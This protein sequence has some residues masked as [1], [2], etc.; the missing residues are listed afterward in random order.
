MAIPIIGQTRAHEEEKSPLP[1]IDAHFPPPGTAPEGKHPLSDDQIRTLLRHPSS[2]VR[3]YAVEQAIE[4]PGDGWNEALLPMVSDPDAR[5]A[6]DAIRAMEER[7]VTAAVDAIVERFS[8]GSHEVA[9]VAA[10][11]LGDLAPEKLLDAVKQRK[12]LDDEAYAATAI[13]L[14]CIGSDEVADFLDKALN[15]AGALAPER[16]GALYGACLLAG[17]TELASRIVSLAVEDSKHDEPEGATYPTRSAF[18]AV[19][20]LPLPYSRKAAGLEVFDHARSTLESDTLPALAETDRPRFEEALRAKKVG[21]VLAALEPILDFKIPKKEEMHATASDYGNVPQRRLGLLRALIGRRADIGALDLKAGAV[22]L[23]A[24]AYAAAMIAASAGREET[25]AGLVTL[26]KTLE[27][28][29]VGAAEL[30]SMSEADLV[31]LFKDKSEHQMRRVVGILTHETLHHPSTLRRFARAIFAAG[32]GEA[33]FEA[34][35]EVEDP[36]IHD[37]VLRALAADPRLA[38]KTLVDA[39]MKTPLEPKLA[40][41]A[42]EGADHVRTERVALAIG[43]RFVELREIARPAVVRAM[44]HIGDPR[45]IELLAARAFPDEP[46]ELAWALLM[47]VHGKDGGEKLER[48]LRHADEMVT[49]EEIAALRLPMRCK[50]CKEVLTYA[51]ERALLD[52][53]SKDPFGDPAFVGETTCKACGAEGELEPTQ[54]A[55]RILTTHMLEF[56]SAARSGRP[57][58]RPRVMP[59]ETQLRGKRVGFAAALRQLD[60]EIK[61]SPSS[62]RARLHRGR[63]RLMLKRRGVDEDAAAVL[64]T[65]PRSAEALALRAAS[66]SRMKKHAEAMATGTTALRFLADPSARLYDADSAEKFKESL[67]DFMVEMERQ[68][69]TQADVDLT[70]ARARRADMDREMQRAQE[71]MAQRSGRA[72]DEGDESEDRAAQEESMAESFRRAGRNDPCPCGSGKKF[73]KCHGKGG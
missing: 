43:R 55:G 36:A 28:K 66:E 18:A 73:K 35:A 11:A 9:A 16:R 24:A 30:A 49:A 7:K 3:S 45:F 67:E 72:P 64:E 27:A 57:M 34:A 25:S 65:D 17:S 70:K 48:V 56:V 22:F 29:G 12:R 63:L 37:A 32:H 23:A 54:E 60:Q 31:V 33:L 69:G 26:A 62:I 61:D 8:T 41:L 2:L 71:A 5:V 21:D 68:T 52:I 15:R 13:A 39:L 40:A 44:L 19:A 38:E 46:E 14:A 20:G 50:R 6:S 4:R 51:F 42:L 1:P 10:G 58:A 59:A 47:Q 53:E